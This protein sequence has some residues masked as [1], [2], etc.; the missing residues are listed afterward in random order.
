MKREIV[1]SLIK[2]GGRADIKALKKSSEAIYIES[3]LFEDALL[4]VTE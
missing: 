2:S 4:E 3:D 1:H